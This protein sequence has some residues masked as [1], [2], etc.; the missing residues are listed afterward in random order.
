MSSAANTI[1]ISVFLW[2][3]RNTLIAT[4]KSANEL[5][6]LRLCVGALVKTTCQFSLHLLHLFLHTAVQSSER[7]RV[8]AAENIWIDTNRRYNFQVHGRIFGVFFSVGENF[9]NCT[10]QTR[11]CL[12]SKIESYFEFSNG[13]LIFPT[14][15]H[16]LHV[17]H[18]SRDEPD[19]V[20]SLQMHRMAARECLHTAPTDNDEGVNFFFVGGRERK[21]HIKS[22][23]TKKFAVLPKN[24]KTEKII[25]LSLPKSST[26]H[27]RKFSFWSLHAMHSG[28]SVGVLNLC[29]IY[30]IFSHTF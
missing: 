6:L 3:S 20:T 16:R 12:R 11:E 18:S 9:F 24:R 28:E 23:N 21:K 1:I 7:D 29:T 27:S 26:I 14:N 17:P 22:Q 15:F 4:S 2:D 5:L 10:P 30:I 8:S 19:N 25:P 13:W